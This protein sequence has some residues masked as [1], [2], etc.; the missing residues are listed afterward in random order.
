MRGVGRLSWWGPP[1]AYAALIF[2]LSSQS[3]FP[4]PAGVWSFDK[5]IHCVEYAVLGWLL[6]RAWL[7]EGHSPARAAVFSLLMAV[8]YGVSDEVHQSYVP[9]RT[10]SIYDAL[11]DAVGAAVVAATW[12]A[13][14]TFT[15]HP[16]APKP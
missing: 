10:S 16:G 1:L 12:Y 8:A 7:G 15:P 13:K 5:G 4:V 3:T 9:G 2:F 6:M 14:R 11:A